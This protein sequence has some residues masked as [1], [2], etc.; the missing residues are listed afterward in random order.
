V[1]ER[2]VERLGFFHT[3]LVRRVALVALALAAM[4]G[5]CR[6]SQEHSSN[7]KVEN[8]VAVRQVRLYFESPDLLLAAETRNVE[9]PENPAGALSATVRELFK[10]SANTSVPRPFPT[11]TV[12]LG[13]YLLPDGTAFVDL[14]GV[15]LGKGWGTGSHAELMAIYSVVQTISTNFPEVKRVRILL[16]GEPTETLAGHI[17]LARA[18]TPMS[19]LVDPRRQ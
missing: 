8:K 17:S 13:A 18:L 9:L 10:G 6:K 11:D 7:L 5:A 19:A 3:L 1:K 2:R 16:N 14:G 4:A 12:V 15:T